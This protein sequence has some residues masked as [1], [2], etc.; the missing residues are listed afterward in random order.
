MN[1]LSLAACAAMLG[2]VLVMPATDLNA[3]ELKVLSSATHK[4]ALPPESAQ[5]AEDVLSRTALQQRIAVSQ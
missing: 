1:K 5:P 2:M 3:A 4:A